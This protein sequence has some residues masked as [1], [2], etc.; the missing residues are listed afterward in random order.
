MSA[1]LDPRALRQARA[2]AL[3]SALVDQA[4]VLQRFQGS[5]SDLRPSVRRRAHRRQPVTP[6]PHKDQS[7]RRFLAKAV[8]G[9]QLV[10]LLAALWLPTF[11]ASQITVSG[12]LCLVATR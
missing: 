11:H 8:F 12:E 7:G 1:T 10:A 2:R 9:V 3:A 6:V 4:P 5:L